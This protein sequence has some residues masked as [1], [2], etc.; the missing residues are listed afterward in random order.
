[1]STSLEPSFALQAPLN[2]R[3]KA[4]SKPSGRKDGSDIKIAESMLELRV[5]GNTEHV[6]PDKTGLD[7]ISVNFHMYSR[8]H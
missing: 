7:L 6:I 4:M 3:T 8:L 5:G 1:L 2:P